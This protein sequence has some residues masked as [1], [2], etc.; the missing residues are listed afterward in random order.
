MLLLRRKRP[1]SSSFSIG[2]S[3]SLINF[4]YNLAPGC[5]ATPA[6]LHALPAPPT[7]FYPWTTCVRLTS[8][9][10]TCSVLSTAGPVLGEDL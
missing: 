8:V 5:L 2:V 4:P 3:L 7:S 10:S 9:Q 6:L 1:P